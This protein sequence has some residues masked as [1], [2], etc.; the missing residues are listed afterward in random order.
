MDLPM[1][2]ADY[3]RGTEPLHGAWHREDIALHLAWWD[4]QVRGAG[5]STRKGEDALPLSE[6][7]GVFSTPPQ[8]ERGGCDA[9]LTARPSLTKG[10]SDA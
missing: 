6:A 3:R 7:S 8:A 1:K 5:A 4:Q 10:D 9:V 2:A